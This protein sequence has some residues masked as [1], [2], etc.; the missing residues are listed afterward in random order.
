MNLFTF[1]QSCLRDPT[2]QAVS[3]CKQLQYLTMLKV[4]K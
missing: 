1:V 3:K 2:K 4:F